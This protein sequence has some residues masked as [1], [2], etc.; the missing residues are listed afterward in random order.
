M[1]NPL[2]F[3]LEKADLAE[4]QKELEKTVLENDQKQAKFHSSRNLNLNSN[5]IQIIQIL[6][7][8]F[9]KTWI[10]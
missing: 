6:N 2:V 5:Y 9:I 8:K 10:T 1:S 4:F 7:S 3:I